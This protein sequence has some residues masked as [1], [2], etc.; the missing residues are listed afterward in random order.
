MNICYGIDLHQSGYLSHRHNPY[1]PPSLL[2]SEW[3]D[4]DSLHLGY[5]LLS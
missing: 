2:L 1:M 3:S 5:S 4:I